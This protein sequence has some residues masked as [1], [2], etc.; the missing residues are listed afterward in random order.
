MTTQ[1]ATTNQASASARSI[2]VPGAAGILADMVPGSVIA[3]ALE[4]AGLPAEGK[5]GDRCRILVASRGIRSQGEFAA[6]IINLTHGEGGTLEPDALTRALVAAFPRANIGQRHGPHYMS[7]AR[8]GNLKGLREGM[9]AIPFAKRRARKP[10][11]AVVLA[12]LKRGELVQMA[13]GL[14]VK[15]SGKTPALIKRIEEARAAQA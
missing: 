15:A 4:A 13:K 2:D 3:A 11:A 1:P 10:K 7:L 9:S 12:D 8:H 5:H 14:G 6:L